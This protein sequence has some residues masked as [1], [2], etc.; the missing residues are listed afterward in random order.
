MTVLT[1]CSGGSD[2]KGPEATL[3]PTRSDNPAR[4]SSSSPGPSKKDPNAVQKRAVLETYNRM[5]EEQVKAYAKASIKGTKLRDYSAGYALAD[6]ETAMDGYQAKGIVA[7]GAP[8]HDVTLTGLKPEKKTPWAALTDCLDTGPWKRV[9]VK[10]G[11]PV[12]MPKNR[13]VRYL[14]KVQAEKWGTTWKI[15]DVKPSSTSC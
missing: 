10:T 4:E 14:T 9:Y 11:K 5:W 13:V 12:D 7:K 2:K 1:A 8:K 6:A 15:V 3:E